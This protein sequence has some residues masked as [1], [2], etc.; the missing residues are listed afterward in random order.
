MARVT[1][2]RGA[3]LTYYEPYNLPGAEI[4]LRR[5]VY[6]ERGNPMGPKDNYRGPGEVLY[7]PDGQRQELRIGADNATRFVWYTVDPNPTAESEEYDRGYRAGW[8][9]AG[10]PAEN[11]IGT[12]TTTRGAPLTMADVDGAVDYN[13]GVRD[14]HAAGKAARKA[15]KKNPRARRNPTVGDARAVKAYKAAVL[16]SRKAS[17][18]RFNL[19][20]GSSRAAVTTANARWKSAAEE[21]DRLGRELSDDVRRAVD[22]EMAAIQN[23]SPARRNPTVGDA[24]AV[25]AYKAAVLASRKASDRR[26]NLPA[27]SSRAAVTTANARWKSAAEE[28][29]RLGR[30]LSDDVRRAVDAEMAAIQN[31]S[32]AR[33]NPSP[34]TLAWSASGFKGTTRY[35]ATRAG[36][37]YALTADPD[38]W[39]VTVNGKQIGSAGDSRTAR[40]I[41]EKHAGPAVIPF[42][43][44]ENPA[45]RNPPRV[46]RLIPSSAREAEQWSAEADQLD[47][48]A[49]KIE[50]QAAV[51]DAARGKYDAS[52]YYQQAF[53]QRER[54]ASLRAAVK[55]YAA[56]HGLPKCKPVKKPAPCPPAP[57]CPRC[58]YPAADTRAPTAGPPP[59]AHKAPPPRPPEVWL[60]SELKGTQSGL[61]SRKN[62]RTCRCSTRRRPATRRTR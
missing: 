30:E 39:I 2:D 23:P 24:R 37:V 48:S 12:V 46:S 55:K 41:A 22:A 15:P 36:K 58:G 4:P 25:K 57:P 19:P 26:F 62:P 33:R 5:Q 27:G 6:D 29:D 49:A 7:A 18:R 13:D 59:V 47:Q 8:K 50:A 51:I 28:R 1:I 21:R 38:G 17:D 44:R 35:E 52:P 3:L 31:P 60:A 16:A 10:G 61:F 40:L 54:A 42:K 32:P 43:R 53:A 14:G 34:R 11:M 9:R 56:A 45:R 20:S